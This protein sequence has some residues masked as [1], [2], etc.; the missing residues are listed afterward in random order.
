MT[1][2]GGTIRIAALTIGI[3]GMVRVLLALADPPTLADIII[4]AACFITAATMAI[5]ADG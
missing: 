3:T 2:T 4:I 1:R 5:I